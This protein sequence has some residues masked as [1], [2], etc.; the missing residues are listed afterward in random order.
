VVLAHGIDPQTAYRWYREGK[1][2]VPARKIGKLILVGDLEA[3]VAKVP[4]RTAVYV[5]VSSADQRGQA[6]T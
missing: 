5:Q 6:I 4:R 1:L 2:S 3:P